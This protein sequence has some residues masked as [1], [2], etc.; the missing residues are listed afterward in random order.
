MTSTNQ[1]QDPAERKQNE[2][3]HQQPGMSK[4]MQSDYALT[5]TDDDDAQDGRYSVAEEQNF[6]QQSE[7]AR[8]VGQVDGDAEQGLKQSIERATPPSP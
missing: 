1:P 4:P 6:D 7:Q 5:Q 2:A 3:G 8:R